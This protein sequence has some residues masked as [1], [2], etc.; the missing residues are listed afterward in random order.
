MNDTLEEMKRMERQIELLTRKINK[1]REELILAEGANPTQAFALKEYIVQAEGKRED[2]KRKLAAKYSLGSTEGQTLLRQKISEL[3][4]EEQIGMLHR[5]NVNRE[6]MRD[7]F[8]DSFDEM[9][10][11]L[12]QFYF[13]S[14]CPTQMPPSFAERMI[15]ELIYEELDNADDALFC[16]R[17]DADARVHIL[18]L[19]LKRNLE[20]CQEKFRYFFAEL[21]EFREEEDFD[22]YL[23]T[24]L[25]KLDYE[26]V[27]PAFE[28][29]ERK[30]K[31]YIAD[32]LKWLMECFTDT[33]EEVPH[34]LFF[35]VIYIEGLHDPER[36]NANK[37]ILLDDLQALADSHD[38]AVHLSPLKPV[39]E[40]D[41][42]AWI[43]DLGEH[44]PGRID[45]VIELMVR[46]LKDKDRQLYETKKCFNMDDVERLQEIICDEASKKR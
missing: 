22:H 8:W 34:F 26:Y 6:E 45:E 15:Y 16:P 7:R 28:L 29:H 38:S 39:P 21:F 20:K 19:P 24:G 4:I 18:D 37:K 14:A 41:L 46:G 44:N 27:T 32:Y 33:P 17:C 13:I 11:L 35:F 23:C 12:F 1:L 40:A 43:M 3:S 25:P 42:R 31:P 36:H 30:W 9:E 2:L 5:V 10:D